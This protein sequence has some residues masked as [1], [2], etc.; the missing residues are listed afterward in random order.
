VLTLVTLLAT[1]M[2]LIHRRR[3]QAMVFAGCVLMAQVLSAGL[4]GWIDR[5]RPTLVGHLDLVYSS[6]F[7]SGHALMTP[8]VYLTLAGILAAGERR[9]TEKTLLLG[10]AVLLTVAV[11][12]SRVYLGVH[13]PSDILAGWILG[14][15]IAL[16]AE[17]VL[18]R[19]APPH[20][21]DAA[22]PP[23]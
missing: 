1:V 12:I 8:V 5:P 6:S 4:K 18:H 20:A 19:T 16:L 13:W 9:R 22:I 15:A 23:G 14:G 11:G 10:V 21:P 17:I 7:P 3:R 2:L